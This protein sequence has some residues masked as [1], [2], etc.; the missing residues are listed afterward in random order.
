MVTTLQDPPAAPGSPDMKVVRVE[1]PFRRLLRELVSFGV[2]GGIG[3]SIT[4]I[5]AN[6]GRHFLNANPLTTVVVPMMVATAVSYF[7]SRAY[8]FRHRDSDGSSREVLLFFGVNGIGVVIQLLCM[9]V[10]TYSLHLDGAISYNAALA[11]GTC[12]GA[13]FRYWSYKK[14]IFLPAGSAALPDSPI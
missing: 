4:F 5:G 14:W 3:T 7:L 6:L 1:T 11:I 12:L 9:G 13:A 10:R 8:T 2:V